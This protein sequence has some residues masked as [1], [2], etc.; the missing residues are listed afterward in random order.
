M[1][2]LIILI[3]LFVLIIIAIVIWIAY[4]ITAAYQQTLIMTI[5]FEETY[6]HIPNLNTKKK[7]K[8]ESIKITVTG[9]IKKK[10]PSGSVIALG[11]N[12]KDLVKETIIDP[13]KG[14]LLVYEAN[15]FIVEEHILKRHP[16]IKDPTLE[17]LSIIFFN[18][19]S[20][21][22]PKIGCQLVSVN[23]ICEDIEVSHSRYKINSFHV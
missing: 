23:L 9:R 19:L 5:P 2:Y 12:I 8:L 20:R 4:S 22:M 3:A 21:V 1:S 6:R 10:S 18:K 14:C 7:S 16:I 11:S 13:Y 17:N 15:T